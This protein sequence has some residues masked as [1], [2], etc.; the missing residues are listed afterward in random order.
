LEAVYGTIYKELNK[1]INITL[2]KLNKKNIFRDLLAL[3]SFK[4]DLYHVTGDIHYLSLFLPKNKSVLTI[5][6][7]GR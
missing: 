6:D 4:A 3:R 7:V 5:H 2:Y 1:K